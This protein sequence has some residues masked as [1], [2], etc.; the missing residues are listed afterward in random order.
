MIDD[1]WQE[2]YGDWRFSGSRFKNPK[3][4]M[5]KLHNMGF[6]VMLWICPF[7]SADSDE[8]RYLSKKG[9]LLLDDRIPLNPSFETWENTQARAAIIRWWNGAS[10]LLDLSNPD[11]RAW[12]NEQLDQLVEEYG[13]DGF[14][15]DAGDAQFYK[16]DWLI[17]KNPSSPNDHTT[18]FAE[19]GLKYPL[20]EYRASW[21]MAGLPLVQRLRD[22]RH[23]W[24]DLQQLVPGIIAQG[25]MGYAYT[26]PD[27][28]G[29]GAYTTFLPGSVIDEELVV[30]SAQT[31]ALMPMMQFSVAPWRVLSAENNQICKDMALLHEEFGD[32]IFKMAE[33]SAISGEPIAR[34]LDYNYPGKGME[35]V[36]GQFMLGTEIL[37]APVT[38][39]GARSRKVIFPEGKWKGE[40]GS[41]VTGPTT[42]TIQVPLERLPYYRLLD[43]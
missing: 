36:K 12:F 42:V 22:K 18:Y 24:G 10:G 25:L 13:V 33:Q 8:F 20:N 16:Y 2:D 34:S 1:N 35:D 29:G 23:D 9:F 11:A 17:S 7:V 40:D 39:K 6:T 41:L 5:D 26:C 19:V 4:M 27:M 15:L 37:V 21:K 32:M 3:G 28:I 38:E 30:R 14:K 31:S 43:K